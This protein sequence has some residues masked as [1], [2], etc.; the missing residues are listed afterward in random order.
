MDDPTKSHWPEYLMEAAELGAFMISACTFGVLLEHPA[1]PVRVAIP[2]D[3]LRRAVMGAAMGLTAIAIVYSPFGRRS[4]AH[5]NPC[6]TLTFLRLGKVAPSDALLYVSAQL[7]GAIG[8]VAVAAFALGPAL[9]DPAV[10]YVVTVPGPGGLAIAFAAEAAISF[11]LMSTVLTVS[12]TP[13]LSRFTGVA[14]GLLVTAYIAFEAPLSGM[15]MNP[16]RTLGSGLAAAEWR[17]LWIYFVAPPLGMLGAAE[18]YLYLFGEDGVFCAKLDHPHGVPCIFCA[19]RARSILTTP[20][21]VS[22]RPTTTT[23]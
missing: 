15:S 11:V 23:T 21:R 8:G 18:L 13:R 22:W 1:S 7:A 3:G 4:G 12:N 6:V 2:A 10:R 16:A 14:C 17:G 20:R 9:A 5:F 19:Y